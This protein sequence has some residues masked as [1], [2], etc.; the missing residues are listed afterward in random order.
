MNHFLKVRSYAKTDRVSYEV[1]TFRNIL[2]TKFMACISSV[3]K[4]KGKLLNSY[5]RDEVLYG[6]ETCTLRKVDQKC[7][8]SSEMWCWRRM[9]KI[10]WTDRVRNEEVLHG[11]E[12]ERNILHTIKRREANWIRYI[13]LRN[14]LIKQVLFVCFWQNSPPVGQGLLIHE[15]SKSHTT[16]QHGW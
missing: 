9:E 14:S 10:V 12:E 6:A 3:V 8:G 4:F 13:L 5:I 11:V 7:L 2:K 1:L 15:V 16:T